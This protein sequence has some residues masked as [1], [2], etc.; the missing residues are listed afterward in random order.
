MTFRTKKVITNPVGSAAGFCD[1]RGSSSASTTTSTKNSGEPRQRT[2]APQQGECGQRREDAPEDH[3]AR[4]HEAPERRLE[5]GRQRDEQAQLRRAEHVEPPGPRQ[6]EKPNDRGH[7]VEGRDRRRQRV[8]IGEIGRHPDTGD[9]RDQHRG[10]DQRPLPEP[11]VTGVLGPSPDC[12]QPLK[13][14]HDAVRRS[15]P[16]RFRENGRCGHAT[17]LGGW[18]LVAPA[19]DRR[20]AF[21]GPPRS[22]GGVR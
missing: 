5:Q 16:G 2:P 19:V 18:G 11:L 15:A 13:E 17:M 9:Q 6:H 22:R 3:P 14:T 8:A 20:H 10:E 1:R 4:C 21:G 7:L 12:G